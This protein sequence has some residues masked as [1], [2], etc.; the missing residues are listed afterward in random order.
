[1]GAGASFRSGTPAY[2]DEASALAAGKTR[3]EIDAWMSKHP[4]YTDDEAGVRSWLA[5]NDLSSEADTLVNAGI[6]TMKDLHKL[7]ED[8]KETL[9]AEGLKPM[10]F[11]WL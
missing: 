10:K 6:E 5:F 9:V 8:D 4:A 7:T 3:D 1:M 2:T 11:R